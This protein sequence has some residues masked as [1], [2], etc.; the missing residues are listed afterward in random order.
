MFCSRGGAA[1]FDHRH[2]ALTNPLQ[3]MTYG[4]NRSQCERFVRLQGG[5]LSLEGND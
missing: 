3:I 1:R 2:D 5:L 4:A